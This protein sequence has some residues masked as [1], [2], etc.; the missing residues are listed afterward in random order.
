MDDRLS[1]LS[2]PSDVAT[3]AFLE[4]NY[5][6]PLSAGALPMAGLP[7]IGLGPI[8]PKF[9]TREAW[10]LHT[11]EQLTQYR[12]FVQLMINRIRAGESNDAET[13]RFLNMADMAEHWVYLVPSFGMLPELNDEHG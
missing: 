1:I 13:E 12:K 2:P 3:N 8:D 11:A 10:P 6:G 9:F 5:T 4:I 7:G